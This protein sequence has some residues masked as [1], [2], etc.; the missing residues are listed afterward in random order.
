M[1]TTGLFNLSWQRYL[2][3]LFLLLTVGF[4]TSGVVTLIAANLDYFSD[5]AKIYGLQTLLVV[6]VV[7]GIYCFMNMKRA[8]PNRRQPFCCTWSRRAL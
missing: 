8:L 7:L 5:L 3:L 4:L 6:T 1:N 2:N